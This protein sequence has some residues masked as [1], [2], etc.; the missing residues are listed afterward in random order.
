MFVARVVKSWGVD[1]NRRT[2]DV[3][4]EITRYAD[5]VGLGFW[6]ITDNDFLV[7][8]HKLDEL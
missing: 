4:I 3:G 8:R 1:Q 7:F 6:A 5:R 2:T